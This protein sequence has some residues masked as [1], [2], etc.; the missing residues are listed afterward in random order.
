MQVTAI[1]HI[2]MGY[3]FQNDTMYG[4]CILCF[5]LFNTHLGAISGFN[6]EIQQKQYK[7]IV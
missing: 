2:V 1:C 5:L 6:T 3:F 7:K 4:E